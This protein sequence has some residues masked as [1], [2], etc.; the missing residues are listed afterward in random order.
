MQDRQEE[1]NQYMDAFLN[2][3][4][5]Q[6]CKEVV[7]KQKKILAL[8]VTYAQNKGVYPILLKSKEINDLSKE[9]PTN[10]DYIEAIMV[11]TQDIEELYGQVLN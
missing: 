8:L 9:N 11:Y 4:F 7:E 10:D 6:K 3:S 5:E 2:L 1:F